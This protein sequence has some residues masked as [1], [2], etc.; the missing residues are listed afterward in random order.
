MVSAKNRVHA[1]VLMVG[2]DLSLHGGIVS[3]V[4]GYL[5]G[6][7]PE[8]CDAFDYLGTGVGSS[9]L[10][11]SLAFTW[12]LIRYAMIMPSYD[13]IHLHI[14]ARGSYKRKSIMARMAHKAGKYVILHDHDGEFKKAFEEGGDSYRRD[15][16][17]TFGI[18]D[19]V[20]V[21]SEEWRDYFSENVCDLKKIIVVHNGVKVPDQP[22]SP[23]SRQDVL[24]L[25]RLD[26]NKSPDVLLRASREILSRF[27]ETKIVFG[28][29]GEV[30]KNKVLAKELGIS[31][32]CEFHGWV[33]GDKREGLFE[34]AAVYCLPSKNEGLPMSVLEA[35]AHG[36]PTVATAVG[37]VPH[38]IEDGVSGF[39]IDVD[40]EVALSESLASLLAE[41]ELREELGRN[42]RDK[43]I[44]K[45]G[46]DRTVARVVG[47]Y[48]ALML[49]KGTIGE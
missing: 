28:G 22:C 7:L 31:D 5:D 13:I 9:K 2:P 20:V 39:L 26:A 40:D 16:R 48:R 3:V 6:G 29:D 42:G 47:I 27:P 17:N 15:V 25:G 19:R 44:L 1:K 49:E 35:M 24:F 11:K 43:V 12:A 38:V 41:P 4:Q 23:C 46:L 37:G 14:S 36:I 18:A 32:R 8:A 30:E 21:L 33:V 10:G 34:R 45:F